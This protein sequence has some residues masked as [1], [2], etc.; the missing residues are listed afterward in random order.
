VEFKYEIV[1][2]PVP[3]SSY[4]PL[5]GRRLFVPTVIVIFAVDFEVQKEKESKSV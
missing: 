3:P 1:Q 5:A 2:F 4:L